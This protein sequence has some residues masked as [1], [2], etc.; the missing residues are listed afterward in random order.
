MKTV[1]LARHCTLAPTG[2]VVLGL[3]DDGT[4]SCLP[5]CNGWS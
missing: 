4:P 1:V 3:A 2:T 5:A